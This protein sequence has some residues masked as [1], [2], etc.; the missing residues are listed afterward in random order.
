MSEPTFDT[1]VEQVVGNEEMPEINVKLFGR[2]SKTLVPQVSQLTLESDWKRL[3][4]SLIRFG[5]G[6]W[7][8][9]KEEEN[10]HNQCFNSTCS[11][12]A[13]FDHWF[14][15]IRIISV[16]GIPFPGENLSFDKDTTRRGTMA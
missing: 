12:V 6:E 13:C 5:P 10:R 8:Q 7:R 2:G 3:S 4:R 15:L 11:G 14:L 9:G 16:G 1:F